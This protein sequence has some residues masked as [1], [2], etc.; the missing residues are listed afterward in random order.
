MH[1]VLSCFLLLWLHKLSYYICVIYLPISPGPLFT[2]KMSCYG[3]RNPHYK[4]KMVWWP[5]H[6]YN[7]NPHT[8]KTVFSW[9]IQAVGCFNGIGVIIRLPQC[10]ESIGKENMGIYWQQSITK[11][12]S[13]AIIIVSS[14][15]YWQFHCLVINTNGCTAK[16]LHNEV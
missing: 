1:T 7:G 12:E 3:Y 13:W 2:K 5:S 16:C 15:C 8:N 9:W 4:P 6:V 14:Y 11:C 10:H